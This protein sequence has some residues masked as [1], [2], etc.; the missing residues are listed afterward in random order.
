[1]TTINQLR[2][3]IN[4]GY[5]KKARQMLKSQVV[6]MTED[7]IFNAM[8]LSKIQVKNFSFNSAHKVN[9]LATVPNPK[10]CSVVQS[11]DPK[12][13]A[14]MVK[15][16]FGE[17]DGTEYGD[18][19]TIKNFVVKKGDKDIGAFSLDVIDDSIRIG[20][21]GIE[22]EFRGTR[23]IM[24]SLL[25]IRDSIID[26]AQQKGI[27]KIVTEVNDGNKQLLSLYQRFGFKPVAEINF[28]SPIMGM[29][30]VQHLLEITI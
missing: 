23:T 22:E 5:V 13:F 11:T 20:N 19:D 2:R 14:Q 24:D 26:F 30:A 3:I 7:E 6:G 8:T 10:T 17:C 16:L 4:N 25:A 18:I 27:S 28:K 9:S 29:D 1:M 12:S 21:F 15:R